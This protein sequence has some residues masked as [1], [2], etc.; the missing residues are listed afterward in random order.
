MPTI[1]PAAP[2]GPLARRRERWFFLLISPWLVGF[3]ICQGGPV[4]G[5]LLLSLAEWPLPR[6][7]SFV[8]LAHFRSLLADPLFARTALNTIYYALGSVPVGI[9][10]G[11]GLALLLQRQRRGVHLLRALFFLPVVV[12]GVA[13]ALVWGWVF[14]PRYGL[15]NA[16]LAGVGI[17][18]PGWLHDEAWA[19]PTLIL[20]SLWSVGPNILIYLAALRNVPIELYEAARLDGAGP[21]ARFRHVTWPMV[22]PV[23]LLL[24]VINTIAALQVFTPSY[25]LTRGGPNNATM[26]LPL[27]IYF[28]AFVWGQLGY[29][30]ALA[31]V[32][33]AMILAATLLQ[34]RLARRAIHYEGGEP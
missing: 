11:L 33:F 19:M 27:Y 31:V 15:A 25:V 6:S 14:N 8:G 10:L 26:T 3:L 5:A 12:P 4:A 2:A 32:L 13:T 17:R 34:R 18:G 30:S 23:T 21:W 22:S 24:V 29:A 20:M 1:L 7:P 28:N 16:L 9:V